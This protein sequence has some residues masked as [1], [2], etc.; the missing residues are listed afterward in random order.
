MCRWGRIDTLRVAKGLLALVAGTVV[1]EWP[2]QD[3]S[4]LK[5]KSKSDS[6]RHDEKRLERFVIYRGAPSREGSRCAAPLSVT[7][8]QRSGEEATG[9]ARRGPSQP[10]VGLVATPRDAGRQ[11]LFLPASS[12]SCLSAGPGQTLR[13]SRKGRPT[14]VCKQQAPRGSQSGLPFRKIRVGWSDVGRRATEASG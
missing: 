1:E 2:S 14:V 6:R 5:K 13:R 9:R 4:G 12:M 7:A 10:D 8:S 3:R 11:P